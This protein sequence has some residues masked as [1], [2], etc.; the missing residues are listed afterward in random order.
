MNYLIILLMATLVSVHQTARANVV[1]DSIN[2]EER[3]VHLIINNC[4]FK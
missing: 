1:S 2:A 4:D 3:I